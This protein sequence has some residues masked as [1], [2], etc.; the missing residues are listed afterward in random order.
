[1]FSVF[2]AL[3]TV[4]TQ[5]KA[6]LCSQNRFVAEIRSIKL[7]ARQSPHYADSLRSLHS[8]ILGICALVESFPYSVEPWMPPLTEGM[9]R[10]TGYQ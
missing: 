7:P 6:L 3:D 5:L 4:Q 2:L 8:A 1:M 9:L 10:C